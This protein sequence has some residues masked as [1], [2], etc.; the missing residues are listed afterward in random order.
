M[1]KF[2]SF[3][4]NN[5]FSSTDLNCLFVSFL[6]PIQDILCF[7]NNFPTF[8]LLT[9]LFW[10]EISAMHMGASIDKKKLTI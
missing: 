7:A 5:I 1:V 10:V 9:F 8:K 2:S 3:F 4:V 6:H